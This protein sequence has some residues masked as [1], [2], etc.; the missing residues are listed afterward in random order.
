MTAPAPELRC[1]GLHGCGRT[2]ATDAEIEAH[3]EN[4]PHAARIEAVLPGESDQ[5]W[6]T[7]DEAGAQ[8]SGAGGGDPAVVIVSDTT[9]G[10]TFHDELPSDDERA[11]Y[12]APTPAELR[13]A[14]KR[15]AS[16][17]GVVTAPPV[18]HPS[19]APDPEEQE[20]VDRIIAETR[21]QLAEA[22]ER[23]P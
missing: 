22:K 18:W 9:A 7:A 21:A 2:F 3:F 20:R 15:N 13:E 19:R 23:K 17:A 12:D 16:A 8:G 4:N 11:R 14:R 6:R 10:R 1:G 5:S